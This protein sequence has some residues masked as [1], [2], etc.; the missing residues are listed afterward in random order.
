MAA[1]LKTNNEW[2]YDVE[3]ML[4]EYLNTAT[5]IDD[6]RPCNYF[7]GLSLHRISPGDRGSFIR[8]LKL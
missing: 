4:S 2:Q 1:L 6:V 8:T 3:A 7:L 5:P